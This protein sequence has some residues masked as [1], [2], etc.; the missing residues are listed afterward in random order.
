MINIRR[1]ATS[2]LLARRIIPARVFAVAVRFLGRH[3]K[4]P[5]AILICRRS[6]SRHRVIAGGK[7]VACRARRDPHPVFIFAALVLPFSPRAR[8][9]N[10]RPF[11]LL[12]PDRVEQRAPPFPLLPIT[13]SSRY[14]R[15]TIGDSRGYSPFIRELLTDAPRCHRSEYV[16]R[17]RDGVSS[18]KR[19]AKETRRESPGRIVEMKSIM[20]IARP[21]E[22]TIT[23]VTS[24]VSPMATLAD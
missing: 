15:E 18:R 12:S 21:R 9:R 24:L 10:H 17:D 22:D 7:K 1:R 20:I 14:D 16:P 11:S 2:N 19:G 13:P 8:P 3:I 23:R 6:G 5:P 4:T